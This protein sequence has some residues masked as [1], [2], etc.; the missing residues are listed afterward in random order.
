MSDFFLVAFDFSRSLKLSEL[1]D[2]LEIASLQKKILSSLPGLDEMTLD[3][4]QCQALTFKLVPVS[5]LFNVYAAPL[6][7]YEICLLIMNVCKTN[8]LDTII[9][10]W[11]RI[12]SRELQGVFSERPDVQDILL[13]LKEDADLVDGSVNPEEIEF[14]SGEWIRPL[15]EKVANLAKQLWGKG[16]DFTVPLSFLVPLL[17][18]ISFSIICIL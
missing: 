15:K 1:Q 14:E 2:K 12:I 17:E 10:L 4:D 3:A 18:G 9:T 5:D 7:L 6:E 13:M 16:A 8:D 11:K